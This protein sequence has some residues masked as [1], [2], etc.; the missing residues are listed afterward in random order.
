MEIVSFEDDGISLLSER[1]P[2][3]GYNVG[4]A[5]DICTGAVADGAAME[6]SLI[7]AVAGVEPVQANATFSY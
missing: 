1:N 7:P 4:K 6:E 5:F 3:T 2:R